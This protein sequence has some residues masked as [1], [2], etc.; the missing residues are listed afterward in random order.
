MLAHDATITDCDWHGLYDRTEIDAN[1]RPV[2]LE[3]NVWLG[4]GA[5]VGKGVHI[6]E[7]SIVG[8][9]AVV[10]RD[11]PANVVVAGNPARIVKKLDPQKGFRTRMDLFK[12]VPA[13]DRFMDQAYAEMLQGNTLLDWLRSRLAPDRDD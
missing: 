6:G 11:V 10:T 7:N 1:A 9:H 13:L 12:D 2:V 3:D 8:A 4:D 5:F